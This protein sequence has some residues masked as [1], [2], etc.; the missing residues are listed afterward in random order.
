MDQGSHWL[1]K[2][3]DN[4]MKN[5]YVCGSKMKIDFSG[6]SEIGGF[7]YQ[8][9]TIECTNEDCVTEISLTADFSYLKDYCGDKLIEFWN[10]LE[11]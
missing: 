6:T 11:K 10:G 4:K 5:C 7:D 9:V 3:V 2:G 8:T 1:F